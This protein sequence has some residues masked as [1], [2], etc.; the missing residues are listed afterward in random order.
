MDTPAPGDSAQDPQ[1][2]LSQTDVEKLLAQVA[3]QETSTIVHTAGG[4][5]ET[6][7]RGTIQPY[8][9]RQP[10]FLSGAELRK[11]RLRHEEFINALAARLSIYLRLEFGLQMSKLETV[12]YQKFIDSLANPT[13]LSLFK[14]EPLRGVC[15][16]DMHPRL[17]LTIVDRL[18]GGPAH[19]VNANRDLSEIE[20]SLLDR[21]VQLILNE[22]CAQWKGVQELRPALLGHETNGR[23]LQT[24]P[25][26][27]VMLVLS[28]EARLGDCIEQMQIAFPFYTLEPLLRSL[29]ADI[30][31]SEPPPA[32]T[33]PAAIQWNPELDDLPL[34]ITAEW[35]GLQMTAG[36][37]SRLKPGDV[38]LLDPRAGNEVQVKLA[39]VPKFAG[40]PGTRNQAWA[41]Q[42]LHRLD[43]KPNSKV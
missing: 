22:W 27:A 10:S 28:M 17:G 25:H 8:D 30:V 26:D 35:Q 12:S 14:L 24:S 23:F 37:L 15:L 33:P 4:G 19:S 21:A 9:F 38:V 7:Q 3:E 41:V 42:L 6:R 39:G 36:Q 1:D 43:Q 32:V 5:T 11:L 2:L 34:Q 20:N 18:L 31:T 40:R 16:L 29:G 13:V